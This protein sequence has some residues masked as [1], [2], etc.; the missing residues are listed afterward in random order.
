M[1]LAHNGAFQGYGHS[2]WKCGTLTGN[3]T[4]KVSM[5]ALPPEVAVTGG[6]MTFRCRQGD[7]CL[8]GPTVYAFI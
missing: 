2:P 5:A 7:Y 6:N 8:I 4:L 1:P 3:A